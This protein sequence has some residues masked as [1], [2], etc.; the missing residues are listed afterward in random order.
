MP[1]RGYIEGQAEQLDL[2]TIL[3]ILNDLQAKSRAVVVFQGETDGAGAVDG[4][5][6][7]CSELIGLPDFDGARVVILSGDYAGQSRVID[8]TTLAGIISPDEA[9][10]GQI[11]AQVEFAIITSGGGGGG[12]SLIEAI[13]DQT[14]KLA[15]QATV[16]GTNTQ[17]WQAAE[18]NLV[19][20]GTNGTSYKIHLLLVGIQNL[21]GNITI[22]LY[23]RINGVERCIYPIP[24][25]TTFSV[26]LDQPEIPVINSSFVIT[27]A[28]RVTV[29]SDNGAD[30]GQAVTYE[31]K[32]EEM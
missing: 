16:S 19:T 12:G 21:I 23:H 5:S 17:N 14:D 6:L 13:K 10:G 32:L 29:Q 24:A 11:Q 20:I 8:G 25:A 22:R 7:I 31:Y 4:S 15:G 1:G 2:R 27:E 30:N 9:F 3:S 18:Q 26:A 28:L